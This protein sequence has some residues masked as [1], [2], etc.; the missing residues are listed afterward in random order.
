MIPFKD[1]PEANEDLANV[2]IEFPLLEP[3]TPESSPVSLYDVVEYLRM[4]SPD[5]DD[6]DGGQLRFVRTARVE[7]Q[8][9][10]IWAFQESDGSSCYVTVSEFA[11][12]ATCVGYSVN[13]YDLTP[14]QFILG[15]Y[16]DVF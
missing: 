12:G 11:D 8:R 10:W 13:D 2:I 1:M 6:I 9:Y 16:H 4:E 5:G 14:E 15:D 3:N 7:E